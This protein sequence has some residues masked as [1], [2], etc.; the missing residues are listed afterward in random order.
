MSGAANGR[1]DGAPEHARLAELGVATVYEAAG[2]TGLIDTALTA[3]IAGARA[4]GPAR[5]VACAQGDNLMV[6]AAI[7]RIRPGEV[8]VLAMPEEA[9]VA[10]I[11]EL[12]VTQ[13]ARRGAAA[14]L[15]NGSVRDVDELR[16]LGLPIW[17]P[18]VRARGAT[19]QE[20]GHLDVPVVIGGATIRP[21]DVV[22]L[23]SD[24]ATCVPTERT[25]EV[26]E[27]AEARLDRETRMRGR[28]EAGEFSYDIHGL[29]D[30]HAD[31][32][33]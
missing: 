26:L 12:L 10:L 16:D 5:A 27:A 24:G 9:P 18:F 30:T 3:V 22:V 23:D 29:R 20:V 1:P 2:R 19:K 21:A 4:A 7:E 25:G 32:I 6:H 33:D 17:S 28:L 8:V 15:T 14:I 31:H 13:I 11:G